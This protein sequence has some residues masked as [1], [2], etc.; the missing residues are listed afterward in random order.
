[1]KWREFITLLGSAATGWPISVHGPRQ[2]SES[3]GLFLD[4]PILRSLRRGLGTPCAILDTEAG[5]SRYVNELARIV[6][7]VD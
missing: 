6:R 7:D 3:R 2:D 4:I 5:G 1:M